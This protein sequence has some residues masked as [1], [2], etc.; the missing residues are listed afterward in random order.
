MIVLLF[1]Y[2]LLQF[3]I[4]YI[5]IRKWFDGLPTILTAVGAFL[6]GVG[7]SIPLTYLLSCLFSLVSKEPMFYAMIMVLF[8]NCGLT[9]Y[10]LI[11]Q[12]NQHVTHHT[13]HGFLSFSDYLLVFFSLA[14]SFWIMG[15]TFRAGPDGQVFVGGNTVFDFGHAL[16]I[17]R[18]LS[19]GANIPIGSPFFAGAPF[20]YHFFFQFWIALWEYFGVPIVWAVNIPSAFSFASLLVTVYY[21]PQVVGKQG[22][23]VG[24]LAV[25][26]TIT[27][28]TLSFWYLL[29]RKGLSIQFLTDMWHMPTYPFAGPFDGSIISIFTTLNP[30]VNQRHLAYSIAFGL[31]CIILGFETIEK[32]QPMILQSA[33]LGFCT[34]LLFMFNM[35][36]SFFVGLCM[37]IMYV[38][39][40]KRREVLFFTTAVLCAV[41]LL[42]IPFLS[43]AADVIAFIRLFYN[44]GLPA[45]TNLTAHW[46]MVQYFWN[47]MGILPVVAL[48]GFVVTPKKLRYFFWSLVALFFIT[49][50]FAA[51]GKRGF[52][53]KFYS[54]SIIGINVLAAVGLGW[55]YKKRFLLRIVMVILVAILTV[56]GV[57][58]LFVLKNEF[59][60][61][62]VSPD[63][64]PLISWIRSTTPKNAVFVS[65]ADIIDPVTLSGR[66]NYFGFFGNA[67]WTD[68]S[69]IVKRIYAG[70]ID[71]ATKLG[72]SYILTPKW[73]KNDFPYFVD[74]MYFK[75]HKMIVYEDEK[76]AVYQVSSIKY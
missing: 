49:C 64:V 1:I 43:R 69:A 59:A 67:G 72:I 7:I 35:S 26:L 34:G 31:F 37:V 54:F 40:K 32:K 4:G 51:V 25:L 18:S 56:S 68:R 58:D 8:M 10:A 63:M 70:D 60:F 19:W 71:T 21:I 74:T 6:L 46:T 75:E 13:K 62:L 5:I 22:K 66:K 44:S 24:W 55:L 17:I 3:G 65:Y 9:G 20:F 73:N 61:P 33:F 41:L 28:S 42:S 36:V 15:K 48:I 50:I 53:Q 47:N 23:L 2:T 30:Y 16:G 38:L 45:Y 39:R 57:I 14:F 52:D 11:R 29:I 27:H 12:H 76:F